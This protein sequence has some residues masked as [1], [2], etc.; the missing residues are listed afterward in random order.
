MSS[1]HVRPAAPADAADLIEA[2]RQSRALHHPWLA[3]CTDQTGFDAWLERAL[4][5]P[6]VHLVARETATSTLVGVVSLSEIVLGLFRNAYL[7][8]YGNAAVMRRGLMTEAVREGLRHGFH[9]V[10]L[11]RIEANIQ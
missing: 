2:N 11:H 7:G 1:V 8:F 6:T 5:G 9:D 10:G 3:P 4:T